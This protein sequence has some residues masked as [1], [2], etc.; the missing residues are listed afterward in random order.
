LAALDTTSRCRAVALIATA[1]VALVLSAPAAAR[2]ATVVSLT[3]DDGAVSQLNARD[4]LLAHGMRGTFFINSGL[5]GANDYYMSWQQIA[6]LAAYGNEIGGHTLTHAKLTELGSS[7]REKEVCDDRQALIAHGF[8]PVSF[9][10]PFGSSSDAVASVVQGCG[11]ASARRVG[12]LAHSN[13]GSCKEAE[14]IPPGDPFALRSNAAGTGP[15]SLSELEGYVTQAEAAGGG[16][17]PLTFHDICS[18][19]TP[20]TVDDSLSPANLNAFLDWLAARAPSGTVVKT[21]RS[22]MGFADAELPAPV[23][24]TAAPVAARDTSTGFAILSARKRQRIRSLHVSAAMSEPGTL[25]A[26]GSVNLR[27]RRY[28]LKSVSATAVPGRMVK[29]RLKFSKKGRRAVRRALRRGK[30]VRAV[31]RIKATDAAGNVS[32]AI[33]RIRLRR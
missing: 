13:C 20:T 32:V 23:T 4:A 27:K 10:Y 31:I 24:A 3:F 6:G 2:A 26:H 28:H 5:V 1:V 33:R 22:V 7:E 17:V 29:L 18:P 8:D 25:S 15:M 9:A 11:Y 16:W 30:R 21:V 14:S 19:C 12:G